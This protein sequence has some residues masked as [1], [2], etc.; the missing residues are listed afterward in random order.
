MPRRSLLRRG[1]VNL[2]PGGIAEMFLWDARREVIKVR[3]RRRCAQLWRTHP[4]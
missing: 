2:V 1:S 3:R 4:T